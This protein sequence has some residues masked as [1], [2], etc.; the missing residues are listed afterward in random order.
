MVLELL[1]IAGVDDDDKSRI[2]GRAYGF[3]GCGVLCDC[4]AVKK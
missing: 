1:M 2:Q 4:T 3:S